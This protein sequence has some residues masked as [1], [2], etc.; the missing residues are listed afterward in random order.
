MTYNIAING[1]GR[2]GRCIVRALYESKTFNK[3]FRL[4][5][6]NELADPDTVYHLTKFDSTHGRFP[7]QIKKG[8]GSFFIGEDEIFLFR[9]KDISQLPWQ[10]HDIDI[11][12]ECT[13]F[14]RERASALQHIK[15]GAKKVIFSN[16]GQDE[17]DA[18]I[19]YGVNHH[20][21]KKEH[22]VVSNASCTTNCVIPVIDVIENEIGIESGSI[23]TIHSGMNDQPVID[24]YN[25]DLRKTR[26][27]LQS[28]IP[29]CT[30]LHRG[31][32][33][34]LPRMQD[35]FESLAIRVPVINVS[36][37]DISLVVK[38]DTDADA[39]NAMLINA[40]EGKLKG[41]LGVAE[42]KMVSCDFNH[43][44]RSSIVD[45]HQTRVSRNRL[46]KIQAWFDNEWGYS[47]R[48]LDTASALME[49]GR[50]QK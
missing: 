48:M 47:N 21:L 25:S 42:E 28:I 34:I 20:L 22:Q 38:E 19:V 18:T 9:Q 29:V 31:I 14:F 41:I 27:A 17:M 36:I 1:Y 11:V 8:K 10:E 13:G 39:V 26:S 5:A 7:L 32:T 12:F 37:M 35:R 23:T 2:I 4:A 40:S 16:P 43:D 45:L 44:P 33:R 50:H 24:A 46:V 3:K 49:A 6:V 30:E 15:A